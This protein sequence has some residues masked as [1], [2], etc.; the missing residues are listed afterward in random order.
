MSTYKSDVKKLGELCKK[1][2]GKCCEPDVSISKK[3]CLKLKS[4]FKDFKCGTRESSYGKISTMKSNNKKICF[5]IRKTKGKHLEAG[6]M[7]KSEDRPL[8]CKLFPLT[9]L[10]E[11]NKIVFYMSDL[12]QYG[13]EALKLKTWIRKAIKDAK[14]DLKSWT[15][16]EKLTRSH[17]HRKIHKGHKHLMPV[18]Y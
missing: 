11:N 12:C 6:C 9:F 3:E 17:M 14:N 2:G 8:S 18:K 10:V 1:C 7:M 16:S 5:F 13:K 15:K 4:K